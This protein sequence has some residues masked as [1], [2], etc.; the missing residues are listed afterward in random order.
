VRRVLH[1]LIRCG[2]LAFGLLQIGPV[3]AQAPASPLAFSSMSVDVSHLRAIG[4]GPFADIVQSAMTDELRRVF[5]DR[6]GGRGPRLVVRVTGLYLTTLPEGG[7]RPFRGDGGGGNV[8]DS[9]DGEAL[10]VGTR[11]EVLAHY[12][13]HNNLHP[14]G[15]WYD[16]LNEQRRAD[17]VSRN[18]AQWLRRYTV[19]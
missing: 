10:V 4:A 3:S 16:P 8:T 19:P 18:Y 12:P 7:G 6:I 5:A 14:Q 13:Q 17:A 9:I 11:G 2:V 15:P 1:R